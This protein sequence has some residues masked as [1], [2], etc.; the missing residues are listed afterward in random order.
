MN[1]AI[2]FVIGYFLVGIF[3][4]YTYDIDLLNRIM[5]C[6]K[7]QNSNCDFIL[8]DSLLDI[9][10]SYKCI[11]N[12]TTESTTSN[13]ISSDSMISNKPHILDVVDNFIK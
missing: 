5:Y 10:K 1:F 12:N 4:L 6:G 9:T 11:H 3:V 7:N 13:S 8:N 2:V